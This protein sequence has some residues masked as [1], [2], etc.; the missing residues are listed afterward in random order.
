MKRP[1]HGKRRVLVFGAWLCVLLVLSACQDRTGPTVRKAI[2][3]T[4]R[5]IPSATTGG[6]SLTV[7]SLPTPLPSGPV[8]SGPV[9][10]GSGPLPLS[11]PHYFSFGVINTPREVSALDTMRRQNGTVFAFRYQYLS[12]GVNTGRG[13]ETWGQPAGQTATSYMQQSAQY[14]YEPVFVYYEICQSNGP[15]GSSCAGRD[16][17]Q[18][19]A[20][21]TSATVMK[22]YYANWVLLLQKIAAFGQPVLIIVEPDLWGY[23]QQGD[24][25]ND[26]AASVPAS[27]SSS[28]FSDAVSY[29]NTA[30]GFA[31]ALLHMRDTYA[32]NALLAIHASLWATR[33][34]IGSNTRSSLDLAGLA[35]RE[36]SFL[37]SAGLQG[38]PAGVSTWDLLSNDVAGHDSGQSGGPIWWDRYNRTFPNFARYLT[39]ISMLNRDTHRRVVMWQVPMGN[40]YFDTMNNSPGHYQDNRAEYILGHVTSFAAAGIISVLFGSPGNGG[41]MNTDR[42]YDGVTNPAPIDSYECQF[43]NTHVSSYSDDDGGYLR[44]FIGAYMQHPVALSL[45]G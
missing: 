6:F 17:Q 1:E 20:N 23:L 42:M 39:F 37:N 18:D 25:G 45:N 41:T 7:P 11:F 29:P 34:D 35:Q 4:T 24:H 32:P 9:F 28:G 5:V 36:A 10:S 12:G 8:S 26:N 3:S 38:N 15:Q 40:Q 22:A 19:P 13:W 2:P 30:Q 16:K 27:V 31:W 43:C 21:L 44:L 14:G 33:T